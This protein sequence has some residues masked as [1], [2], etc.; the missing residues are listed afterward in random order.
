MVGQRKN[1]L[2]AEAVDKGGEG[3]PYR[4]LGR[5][6]E[7]VSLIGLGGSSIGA[8]AHENESIRII[9]TALDNGINFLDGCWDANP[10]QSETR[11]GKALRDGYRRKAFL[12][13]RIDG[14]TAPAA[15][16]QLDESLQRLQTDHVDLLHLQGV[17]QMDDPDFIFAPGGALEAMLEA[18][19]AGKARYLGFTGHKSP[20]VHL[21]MLETAA[22]HKFTFDTVQMPLNVLDARS[23]N[24]EK[25]VLPVALRSGLGVLAMKPMGDQILLKTRA[26]NRVHCLRYAM[27]LPVSVVITGCDSLPILQQAWGV[28]RSFRPLPDLQTA[29]LRV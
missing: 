23:D 9:R 5:T 27:S 15:R 12:M 22:M 18:Q 16:R 11:T 4:F 7:R 13:T 26:V 28:A 2:A 14:R 6:G 1:T 29:S 17:N 21:K 19:Q 3:M 24:F 8:Q 10:I 20:D 25:R